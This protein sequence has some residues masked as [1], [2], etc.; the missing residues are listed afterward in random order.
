MHINGRLQAYCA[1]QVLVKVINICMSASTRQSGG[2]QPSSGGL[3]SAHLLSQSVSE[4]TRRIVT[5]PMHS[6]A[7]LTLT[8]PQTRTQ[9]H[10]HSTLITQ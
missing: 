6:L 3:S 1:I 8:H 7:P 2:R 10:H 9:T 4:V 5:N